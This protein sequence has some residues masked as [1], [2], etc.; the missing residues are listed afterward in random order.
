MRGVIT[1][2]RIAYIHTAELT[3]YSLH[4]QSTPST[5]RL[6]LS[7]LLEN[8]NGP[9]NDDLAHLPKKP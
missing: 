7:Q 9:E 2:H 8:G 1:L 4:T 3:A 6:K 5:C